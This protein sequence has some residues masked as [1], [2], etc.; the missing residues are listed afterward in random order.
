MGKLYGNIGYHVANVILIVTA[1]G[2]VAVQVTAIGYLFN[3]FF[4]LTYIKGVLIG[5]GILTLYS[6]LGGVRAVA[7]TDVFQFLIF[8]L[9]L[10]LTCGYAYTQAGGYGNI[11]ES[12]P[13][14][15]FSVLTDTNTT[16]LF[17]GY[18]FWI[19][20]PAIHPPYV[21]RLLMAKDKKQLV[22]SYNVLIVASLFFAIVI[23]ILGFSIRVI[24]PNIDAR[25][26]LYH[27][28][29]DLATIFYWVDGS[30][31]ISSY[32]VNSRFMA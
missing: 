17:L 26:A 16:L 6:T 21:Q 3:Y 18:I 28:V 13:E 22:S 1:I 4:N 27:F 32:N 7:L 5:V 8:F 20:L 9:A 14:S 2:C 30:R 19:I 11:I 10:P 23:F 25:M 15:H 31:N 12:L 29:G 24:Y